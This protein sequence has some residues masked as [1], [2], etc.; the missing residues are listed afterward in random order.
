MGRPAHCFF[1]RR[2][3]SLPDG[4]TERSRLQ[5]E[6]GLVTDHD[7]RTKDLARPRDSK[8]EITED[9]AQKTSKTA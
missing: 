5:T 2:V 8:T 6:K 3:T 4:T 1:L 9:A 7:S